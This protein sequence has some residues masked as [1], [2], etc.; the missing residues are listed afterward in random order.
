MN[1]LTGI[2]ATFEAHQQISL[3]PSP[4][5]KGL[6]FT[7]DVGK[8]S[9]VL[10]HTSIESKQIEQ[11]IGL[12]PW[13]I[14]LKKI[15]PPLPVDIL[16]HA[17]P[18]LAV[19]R[20]LVWDVKNIN[21][22]A[23][24]L[25]ATAT[26]CYRNKVLDKGDIRGND[27]LILDVK[28]LKI[29]SV[30]IDGFDVPF[31][32]IE[33]PNRDD[34]NKFDALQITIATN[35]AQGNVV[36]D[37]TT[38]PK[39]S[40][41]FWIDKK[42][43]T[44]KQ[45]PLLYTLFQANEGASVI[46]GQH[47]PQV[48]LTWVV[49]VSTGSSDLMALSSVKNNPKVVSSTGRYEGMYMDRRIPLYLLCL[50]IGQMTFAEYL[51]EKEKPTGFGIYSE[52]QTLEEAKKAFSDMPKYIASAEKLF[53]PY[54]WGRYD[55]SVLCNAFPYSAMEHACKSTFG[56][57]CMG[58]P[59]VIAHEITH[60]WLG[61]DITNAT[62]FE[63]FLNEGFTVF[64]E[65]MIM[66]EMHGWDHAS[67]VMLETLKEMEKAI[68]EY[69]DSRPGLLSLVSTD[70]EF[71]RIPY[72]KGALFFFMLRESIG[73]EKFG[74]FVKDYMNMFYQNSISS[75]QFLAFLKEWLKYEMKIEDFEEFKAENKIDD[76]LYGKEIPDNRPIFTSKL[77]D[78]IVAEANNVLSDKPVNIELYNQWTEQ[79][80][81][82]F[83]SELEG[84]ISPKQLAYLDEQLNPTDNISLVM[85]N[86]WSQ[87]FATTGY[88]TVK[89]KE[90][91]I[92]FILERN[93]KH[94]TNL[95]SAALCKT[96][97]G[98]SI[99]EEILKRGKE[100]NSLFEVTRSVIDENIKKNKRY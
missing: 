80:K 29:H 67:L 56:A 1:S 72:G 59:E 7:E 3:N 40:G 14:E 36:I 17:Q 68:E 66:A 61:N 13:M 12:K 65:V 58:M 11:A 100:K 97:E 64:G 82:I 60:S 96:T 69:R 41:L 22:D 76:W 33:N 78:G 42:F 31:E 87:I 79:M 51:D 38:H 32:I 28:D 99:A 98:C 81:S 95:I 30:K 92:N 24:T 20:H 75:E 49:N 6:T 88:Y 25:D 55:A 84:K 74:E 23:R 39:A 48:R 35:K 54:K 47:S 19:T 71:T 70:I 16:S 91:I 62:W 93:S 4:Q 9:S 83:L 57:V 73:H 37:Y 43:T 46:P 18:H 52:T 77:L 26:Y 85:R 90:F 8:T 44:G 63:F 5:L 45:Y 94:L 53:G 27:K 50:E 34:P 10:Y 2:S 89:T 86:S 21:F 15:L